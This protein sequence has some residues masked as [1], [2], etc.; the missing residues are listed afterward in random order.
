MLWH[1]TLRWQRGVDAALAPFSLTH[2][3]ALLL[4][5]AWW[6]A[7]AGGVPNQRQV[8]DHAGVGEVMA[9]QIIKVLERNG[10]IERTTHPDDPRGKALSV[11]DRGRE[12][13][14]HAVVALD[15]W[16]AQFFASVDEPQTVLAALQR[17]AGRA[18]QSS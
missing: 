6:L 7:R 14:E 9:S 2:G 18:P 17:L 12:V 3:Q 10:L 11:T 5:S 8:A 1:T 4:T 15:G 16:D 13:A